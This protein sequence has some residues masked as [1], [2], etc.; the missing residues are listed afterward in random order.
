[1]RV[2]IAGGLSFAVC[3]HVSNGLACRA[4][5]CREGDE[6]TCREFF[7]RWSGGG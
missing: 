6:A 3:R 5:I 2:D 4:R 1:M 7:S